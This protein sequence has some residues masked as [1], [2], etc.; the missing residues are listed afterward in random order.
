MTQETQTT[1]CIRC[2]GGKSTPDKSNGVPTCL[3]CYGTGTDPVMPKAKACP[4]CG[5]KDPA[6]MSIEELHTA[7]A[8]FQT[9]L[10]YKV[11]GCPRKTVTFEA[12]KE[13]CME[14][15]R[16]EEGHEVGAGI[17]ARDP[18]P[19]TLEEKPERLTMHTPSCISNTSAADCNC[20]YDQQN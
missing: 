4:S 9:E 16:L 7:I 20:G 13:W 11:L 3:R 12:S 18:F 17:V 5:E 19:K 8:I 1:P 15:A 6:D 2:D 10:Q 14:M